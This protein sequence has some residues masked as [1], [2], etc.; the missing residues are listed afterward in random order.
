MRGQSRDII[1]IMGNAMM[2]LEIPVYQRLY[3]WRE[4]NCAQLLHDLLKIHQSGQE[5]YFFG[6]IVAANAPVGSNLLIIDGQQRLTTISL[7][8]LAAIQ[9][10]KDHKLAISDSNLINS[11]CD[12][13]LYS[14][15]CY[16][17]RKIKLVPITKD[18]LAYDKIF[19]L[20]KDD[21]G[22]IDDLDTNSQCTLNFLYFYQCLG[23]PQIPLSFDQLFDALLRLQ[24]ILI[25]L[26]RGD[27]AQMIFESLNST[28]MALSEADKVRNYLLMALAP[29]EQQE[30]FERYWV[31]IEEAVS[32]DTS[33]F[34]RIY[35][36]LE[37]NLSCLINQEQIY[38][39]WKRFM[40]NRE[41]KSELKQMLYYASLYYQ[42]NKGEFSNPELSAKMKH[43][44]NLKSD[45]YYVFLM[46]FLHYAHEQS[47]SDD[48][49]WKV[50]DLIEN[51]LMRRILC[52]VP[53]NALSGLFCSLHKAVV[54]SIS[55]SQERADSYADVLAFN[56]L[57]RAGRLAFQSDESF[58]EAIK[59][60]NVYK[61]NKP[62][63]VFLFERLE[64]HLDGEINNVAEEMN[65][66]EATI[67]HIMPQSLCPE[68]KSM[69]GK[70]FAAIHKHYVHKLANLTLTGINGELSNRPFNEKR[71]GFVNA[72]GKVIHGYKLSKYRLTRDVSVCQQW[73]EQELQ[74]RAN[75]MVDIL[76]KL[77]PLPKSSFSPK[78]KLLSEISLDDD[79]FNPV[80]RKL[81]GYSLF[82]IK[83][84]Q[85]SWKD[86]F[87]Q[88]VKKV[89][90]TYPEQTQGL[91]G[92]NMYFRNAESFD[93][94]YCSP[95][96]PGKYVR[97]WIDNRGK[98]AVLKDLFRHCNID[99]AA[100]VFM[101]DP[102]EEDNSQAQA[103]GQDLTTLE[104]AVADEY[105]LN[106]SSFNPLRRKIVGYRLFGQEFKTKLWKEF[107]INVIKEL[108]ERYVEAME[109]LY[110]GPKANFA[111]TCVDESFTQIAP[112]CCIRTEF[113]NDEKIRV[114]RSAFKACGVEGSELVIYLAP[115]N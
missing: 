17:E 54:R 86:M 103:Q 105:A 28:G 2:Q 7:L 96:A 100:L 90:L 44:C 18:R 19:A 79:S 81:K 22:T 115:V 35:L 104:V 33:R 66:H 87:V 37:Q 24:I 64:N 61:L 109:Q 1:A 58:C 62:Y 5:K 108:S 70:N 34:L 25:E 4:E 85:S 60:C 94:R 56:L 74:N 39:E 46:Q 89:I 50:L 80:K 92:C 63:Q 91:F 112:G 82:G 6:S 111:T 95:V 21:L 72:H 23:S 114:L 107:L 16:G 14:P 99:P 76:L 97:S 67:E 11:A 59:N 45:I 20:V 52:N 78:S 68:W 113:S 83:Y 47:L 88:V 110:K 9:A 84:E 106:D 65:N 32:Y 98:I 75:L 102:Q 57:H 41:R 71:D 69:L 29:D 49:I 43:L 8:L 38:S 26:E 101:V 12:M 3:S 15:Y 55:E 48:V 93:E 30:Y 31:K 40:E 27:D 36:T 77:Y 53:S 42:I 51:Y 10:V 73:T 13:F